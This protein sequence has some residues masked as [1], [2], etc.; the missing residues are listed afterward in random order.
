MS[1]LISAPL[2]SAVTAAAALPAQAADKIEVGFLGTL[3]GPGGALGIDMRDAFLP[4]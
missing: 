1:R 3:S 2:L 4:A